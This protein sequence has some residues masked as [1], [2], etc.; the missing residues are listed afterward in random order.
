MREIIGRFM[1]TFPYMGEFRRTN[2]P[3]MSKTALCSF[4]QLIHKMTSSPG[5]FSIMRSVLNTLLTNSSGAVW[6]IQ[7]AL[8]RSPGVLI[9]YGAYVATI[10]SIVFLAHVELIKSYDAPELN[11]MIIGCSLRVNVPA[12]TFVPVGISSMVV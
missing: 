9:T 2:R 5:L 4:I 8:T 11:S 6:T 7:S 1:M 3:A 12:S 10:D